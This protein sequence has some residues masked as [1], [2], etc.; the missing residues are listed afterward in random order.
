[1]NKPIFSKIID[2]GK[3]EFFND[4][5]NDHWECKAEVEME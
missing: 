3:R 4:D 1:M 5:L 2:I